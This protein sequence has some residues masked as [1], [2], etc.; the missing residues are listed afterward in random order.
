M[1]RDSLEILSSILSVVSQIWV[2]P[3][4][5]DKEFAKLIKCKNDQFQKGKKYYYALK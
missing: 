3:L 4:R 5:S 1:Q 2:F